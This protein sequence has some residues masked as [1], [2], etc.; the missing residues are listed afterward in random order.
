M[1][2]GDDESIMELGR[3]VQLEADNENLMSERR[4]GVGHDKTTLSSANVSLVS[5]SELA[6][7]NGEIG[8]RL[9]VRRVLNI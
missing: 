2:S 9:Q 7:V 1:Y 6:A 8:E 4:D 3:R 5:N